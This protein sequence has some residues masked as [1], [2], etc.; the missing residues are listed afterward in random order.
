MD[1][2]PS[3]PTLCIM[4]QYGDDDLSD[5]ARITLHSLTLH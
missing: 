2:D 4:A 3:Q 5:I 1:R